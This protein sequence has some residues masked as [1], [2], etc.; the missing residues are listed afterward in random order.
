MLLQYDVLEAELFC[1]LLLLLS[2]IFKLHVGGLLGLSVIL[3][4]VTLC[5][6]LHTNT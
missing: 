3:K 6:A 4:C 5:L 2:L 1:L